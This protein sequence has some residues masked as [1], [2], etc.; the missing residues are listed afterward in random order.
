MP[1]FE[2]TLVNPPIEDPALLLKIRQEKRIFLFDCGSLSRLT[3]AP[4][5]Q[6]THIFITHAHIDHFIGFDSILRANI[7]LDKTLTLFGPKGITRQ[8]HCKVLAYTWNLITKDS[9][10]FKIWEVGEREMCQTALFP[11][12]C[13][14]QCHNCE[15]KTLDNNIVYEEKF[16]QIKYAPLHHKTPCLGYAIEERSGYK[17]GYITDTLYSEDVNAN[18][19][20][21]VKDSDIFY[22]G[23]HYATKDLAKAKE[24]YHLTTREAGLLARRA[25]AKQVVG[26]HFSSRYPLREIG[27]LQNEIEEAFRAG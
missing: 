6:I 22:C 17:I 2:P 3:R 7:A 24:T 10:K 11:S 16:F 4:L 26:F 25:H 13:F 9:L 19:V 21:L 18:I 1:Y 5:Q 15:E 23:A 8:I 12:D 20:N 27:K 14:Q